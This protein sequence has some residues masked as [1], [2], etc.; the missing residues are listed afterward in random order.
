MRFV[1]KRNGEMQNVGARPRIY[2]LANKN[3]VMVI[4]K[5]TA[6][7]D[8]EVIVKG[9]EES[10]RLFWECIKKADLRPLANLRDK[11]AYEVGDLQQYSC[12]V[13]PDFTYFAGST[14]MEQVSKG[15]HYL[16]GIDS[17]LGSMDSKLGSMDSKLGSMD[18]KLADL[19]DRLAE[20]IR[21]NK[22]K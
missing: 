13:E 22:K 20:A 4:P 12:D 1:I 19:P 2:E 17:K 10:I 14:T 9:P 6:E 16:G 3:G 21:K 15:T 5:N 11:N 18:S 8:I 7:G